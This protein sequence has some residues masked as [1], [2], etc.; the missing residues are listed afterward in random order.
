MRTDGY[1]TRIKYPPN[2]GSECSYLL[3]YIIISTQTY[4]QT[5]PFILWYVLTC[6][7]TQLPPSI[8]THCS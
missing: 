6:F 7:P 2:I 4:L 3:T 8:I 1:F 5:Y